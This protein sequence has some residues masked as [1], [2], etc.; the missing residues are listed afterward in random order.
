LIIRPNYFRDAKGNILTIEFE[1]SLLL[2]HRKFSAFDEVFNFYY[3]DYD[4]YYVT[5]LF[6]EDR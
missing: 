5:T 4:V 3:L 6:F 1:E 2:C